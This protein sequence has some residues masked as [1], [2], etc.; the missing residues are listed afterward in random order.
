MYKVK[1]RGY[2][3]SDN[4]SIKKDIGTGTVAEYERKYPQGQ[5][6]FGFDQVISKKGIEGVTLYQVRWQGQPAAENIWVGKSDLARVLLDLSL[7]LEGRDMFINYYL[8]S[9]KYLLLQLI[10]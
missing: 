3:E 4:S 7:P 8:N 5:R 2:P 6:G 1:W 10:L 9:M